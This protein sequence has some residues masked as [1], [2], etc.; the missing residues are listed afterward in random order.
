M[1]GTCVLMF[2][3]YKTAADDA[4]VTDASKDVSKSSEDS[5]ESESM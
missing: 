2:I 3:V 5:E 4:M 1:T